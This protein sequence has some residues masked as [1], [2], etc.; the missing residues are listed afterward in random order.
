MLGV[1]LSPTALRAGWLLMDLA[2][3][4]LAHRCCDVW[5]ALRSKTKTVLSKKYG[6]DLVR[7]THDSTSVIGASRNDWDGV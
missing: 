1:F 4:G 2:W 3:C 5:C 7:F 6:I